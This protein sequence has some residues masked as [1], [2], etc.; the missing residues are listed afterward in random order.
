[1]THDISR[2]SAEA[3][4]RF[5]AVGAGRMGR[6][7]AI[8]FAYAGYR[9]ALVDLRTRTPDAWSKL[10]GDVYQEVKGALRS[11]AELDVVRDDQIERIADRIDVI[12]QRQAAEALAAAEF[13]VECVPETLAAKQEAFDWLNRHCAETAILTSTTSSILVTDLAERVHRPE[14]FLNTHWLNPAYVVPLVE[15]S[16]HPGTSD[17]VL[18]RTQATLEAIGKLPVTCGPT[19]GYIVPRLQALI[20]NEAARMVEEGAAT[21]E[22]IDKATRYGLGLRFAS[23]GVIEF[24]DF[25][26]CDILYHASKTMERLDPARFSPPKI[27]ADKM[28]NNHLGLKTKS[29]FYSYENCDEQAYRKDVLD[30]T[31]SQLRHVDMLRQPADK[32]IG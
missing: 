12:P 31:L 13:V 23:I 10:H 21:V 3:A 9:I 2:N 14:R 22:Q 4:A 32:T 1:M 18:A 25:G 11:L 17:E 29:G 28:H 16:F 5:V 24:I 26:G 8:A 20:M 30:R 6:G 15:V 19:T 7:I 27:V